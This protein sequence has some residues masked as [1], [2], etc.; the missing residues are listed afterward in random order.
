MLTKIR[1]KILSNKEVLTPLFTRYS[2]Y[3]VAIIE[4]FLLPKLIDEYNYSQFEYYKNLIFLF[5]NFLLGSY[6]GYVYLKYVH[7][8]DYYQQLFQVGSI[9]SLI[10]AFAGI[11]IFQN[12]Y[13]FIPFITF[14]LYTLVEQKLKVERKFI[15]IFSYKPILSILSIFLAALTF[16]I[17][18]I[19]YNF[20]WA[21]L[22]VFGIGFTLWASIF[23]LGHTSFPIGLSFNRIKLL[24]Y[25]LMVKVI[26]TG[27]LASLI[28]GLMVFFERY[29]IK[30][31]YP[32]F[33][34]TYSLAFNFSQIVAVL[35]SAVSYVTSVELGER[36][37]TIDR[38]KLWRNFRNALYVF[39]LFLAAFT[40]FIY[41]IR[42]FYLEFKFLQ[43]V[44]FILSFSK[45][46]FYL[47]GTVS[48]LAVYHNFNT[49]M[50]KF[51]SMLFIINIILAYTL[52]YFDAGIF[53][54]LIL[55]SIVIMIYSLFILNIVFNKISYIPSKISRY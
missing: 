38:S 18:P 7:K 46:F 42:G 44:T 2:L 28:F 5:P 8:V 1:E 47:I 41:F 48:H 12:V 15:S 17:T 4:S 40:T 32:D 43:S 31:Y 49:K 22:F 21:L 37:A 33:L 52:I 23:R 29:Y 9:I 14:N 10:L 35:L 19:S 51:I 27:V 55:D 34:P 11:I 6:S 25:Y 3:S 13:L 16:F 20:Q 24:R 45:G 39:I 53:I 36:L 54:L 50:F 30:Q 26:V